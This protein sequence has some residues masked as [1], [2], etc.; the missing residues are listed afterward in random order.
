MTMHVVVSG[1]L[2]GH[3][4]GA[5]KR[6]LAVLEHAGKHLHEGERI[7][8]LHRHEFAPPQFERI[9]WL[10]IDIPT[11]PTWRRA[12][13]EQ[14][15]LKPMLRELG[16]TVYD[17]GFLPPPRVP[18]P[19]ALTLHDLRAAD[20]HTMWPQW[21]ARSVL[22]K[23]CRRADAII[24]P[25]NWTK[26]RL[27]Q[28]VANTRTTVAPNGFTWSEHPTKLA[29]E[30]PARGYLLHVG[31]LEARKNLPVVLRALAQ[32]PIDEAPELW[33]A[34]QDAGARPSLEQLATQLG[35]SELVQFLGTVDNTELHALYHH[36]RA[37]VMPSL[38]EGFGMP[39]LEGLAYGKPVLAANATALPEVLASHGTLLPPEL[40]DAWAHA[41]REALA[42]PP[43]SPASAQRAEYGRHHFAWTDTAKTIVSLWRALSEG[44]ATASRS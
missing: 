33:L 25:S 12:I 32:M 21:F 41:I 39:A 14:F 35:I 4:S 24:T 7:T 37:I 8:V 27:Q 17:H 40:P 23:A 20:G 28:L 29:R 42:E 9:E 31:H 19:M 2:L 44:R 5:N 10:P 3:H 15:R 43:D 36:A 16:A 22:R 38:Y 11:G 1:W 18:I 13:V 30:L 26:D 34:G 6:L